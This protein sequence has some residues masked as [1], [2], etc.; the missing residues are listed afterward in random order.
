MAEFLTILALYYMCDATATMRPMSADEIAACTSTYD[1]VKVYF[2]DD[3]DLA[4]PGTVDRF[5][6]MTD[7]YIAFQDWEEQNA[8]MVAQMRQTAWNEARGYMVTEG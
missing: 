1:S 8:D 6:Q 3:F 4:P 2:V 7:A 5:R